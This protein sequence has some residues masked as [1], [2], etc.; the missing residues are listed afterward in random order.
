MSDHR[1]FLKV[2]PSIAGYR[3]ILA[4]VFLEHLP[5]TE[6][7]V[8]IEAS[9]RKAAEAHNDDA[10]LKLVELLRYPYDREENARAEATDK[11]FPNVT[12]RAY[13]RW[14]EH[15]ERLYWQLP[16]KRRT[17][18]GYIG[19]KRVDRFGPT[20]EKTKLKILGVVIHGWMP[21]L[22]NESRRIFRFVVNCYQ[23]GF[24]ASP[25]SNA[26]EGKFIS[27]EQKEEIEKLFRG[28]MGAGSFGPDHI[29]QWL[30]EE[31]MPD[32][33]RDILIFAR[34]RSGGWELAKRDI[35]NAELLEPF[36]PDNRSPQAINL[37]QAISEKI[38]EF[39]Q[40]AVG[41]LEAMQPSGYGNYWKSDQIGASDYVRGT[42]SV[43]YGHLPTRFG[44]FLGVQVALEDKCP[45][46]L[47]RDI[48]G[49]ARRHIEAWI[50]DQN[51]WRGLLVSLTVRGGMSALEL[52][53]STEVRPHKA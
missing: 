51:D 2:E 19:D 44:E 24:Y 3:D 23:P 8:T 37:F 52:A 11:H 4:Q 49:R 20:L 31:E 22:T 6:R 46:E 9:L 15:I 47:G 39:D 30:V 26:F 41:L 16:D 48:F 5:N 25:A 28:R 21:E 50:K 10:C 17:G 14:C 42:I 12:E 32:K 7:I 38:K 13:L 40:R 34:A 36:D 33:I 29:S 53:C 27:R 43:T 18:D 1:P 35:R 45:E